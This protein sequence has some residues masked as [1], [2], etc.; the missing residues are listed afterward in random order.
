[1]NIGTISDCIN[2]ALSSAFLAGAILSFSACDRLHEDLQPCPQGLKLRFV[3]DYN[4]EYANAFPSQVDCLTLLVYDSD[5]NYL[6][7]V[8]A[9][10]PETADEDW[11]MTIN[12]PAGEYNLLAYGGMDCQDASFRFNS[13]PSETLMQNLQ[14][15][16][17]SNLITE[18]VGTD[19]HP[20]FYGRLNATVPMMGNDTDYIE[21]TVYMMKDTNDIRIMLANENGLPIDTEKFV[22]TITDNNTRFNYLN[23]VI[24]TEDVT[25]YPWIK[26]N[27]Q[28]GFFE[29][30]E[31]ATAAWAEFS[32][33]RLVEHSNAQLTVIRKEGEKKVLSIPLVEVLLLLK[34]EHF[35]YMDP[36]QFLDRESRW[37]LTF[38][39]TEKGVWTEVSI[40]INDWIVRINNISNL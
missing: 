29:D 5:G 24:S 38:F 17:P 1:M 7:T 31:P 15:Y 2:K 22:Y 27:A 26:D 32:V 6:Q 25:Y 21:E 39:L 9:S 35:S 20:L 33:P 36:Q 16:L 23:S 11:R 28:M 8:T 4:M 13:L 34:S 14:V 40:V 30:G 18:S 3:Y 37:N 12:L 19:L 10:R